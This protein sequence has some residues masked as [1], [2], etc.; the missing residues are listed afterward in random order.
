MKR[1]VPLGLAVIIILAVVIVAG[2]IV[3]WLVTRQPT[4]EGPAPK[5][6]IPQPP[7]AK[8]VPGQPQKP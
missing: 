5:E 1:E 3:W 4:P 2:G 7:Y 6:F 8:Q